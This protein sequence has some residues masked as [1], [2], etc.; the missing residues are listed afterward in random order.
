MTAFYNAQCCGIV[1]EYQELGVGSFATAS[2][3]KIR[4][5]N[6]GFTLAG[7]RHLLELLRQL[8]RVELLS[9]MATILVTGAAGFVGQHLLAPLTGGAETVPA[10]IGPARPRQRSPGVHWR[11][12]ELLDRESVAAALGAEPARRR[13]IT[14]PAW[15]TSATRGRTPK[16]PWPATSSAPPTSS[17]ACASWTCGRAWSSPGRRRSTR[18]PTTPLT[19]DS[20]I[21][22]EHALRHQQAGAGDGGAGGLARARACRPWSPGRSTTSVPAVAGL[23]RRQLR[24]PAGAIEAGLAAAGDQRRQPRGRCA[25]SPT[26]ATRCARIVALMARGRSGVCYNVCSGRAVPDAGDARRPACA[27][28]RAGR[29]WRIDPA[30]MRPVD[31]PVMLGSHAR[32]TADTGWSAG[33]SAS[34]TR[35][36]RCS[37][38]GAA[39][40]A[41]KPLSGSRA[42]MR[43]LTRRTK[44]EIVRRHGQGRLSRDLFDLGAAAHDARHR[45]A[46]EGRRRRRPARR[47]AARPTTP[48]TRR[49]AADRPSTASR[50]CRS[51]WTLNPYRGCTHGC[52]YCFARKYQHQL[53]LGEGDDFASVIFVKTNF[54]E[55]LRRELARPSWTRRAG[56]PRHRHRSLSADRGHLRA[57]ARRASK[58]VATPRRRSA[59]SP[60]GRWWCAT[61]TCCRSCRRARRARST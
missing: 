40:S 9:V 2:P 56:G 13:S 58:R 31:T 39:K 28:A 61:S 45:R 10:G 15:P 6:I 25:T 48:P 55:V 8:R 27:G 22:P 53:E 21:A 24:A 46:G 20:P 44:S 35:S 54:V 12:V 14:W 59:S 3:L 57:D 60:R 41:P 42:A 36:T 4:R 5:F 52:H 33:V 50:A 32:L 16:R 49:S 30:R 43:P 11:A 1:F 23:R 29:R 19:E 17:T 7:A 38:T 34:T 26:C 51:R 18:R 37:T 47:G